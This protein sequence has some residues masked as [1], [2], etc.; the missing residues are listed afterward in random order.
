MTWSERR[1]RDSRSCTRAT[2]AQWR[3]SR[4]RNRHTRP[5]RRRRTSPADTVPAST[6]RSSRRS[7]AAQLRGRVSVLE[8]TAPETRLTRAC[9]RPKVRSVRAWLAQLA[10]RRSRLARESSR[11]A[12]DAVF[13]LVVKP[14]PL[15]LA[16]VP[17]VIDESSDGT[18]HTR[19]FSE[20]Q[21]AIKSERQVFS[22]GAS[23]AAAGAVRECLG[24]RVAVAVRVVLVP[25]PYSTW[26]FGPGP[27]V[28]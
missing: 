15:R 1:T 25:A 26:V 22:A 7:R 11:W 16:V 14:P 5:T 12:L 27:R 2:R 28:K 10:T 21:I 3:R 8:E 18:L 23:L 20:V 17:F 6:R 13:E 19:R 4:S 24:S 9:D